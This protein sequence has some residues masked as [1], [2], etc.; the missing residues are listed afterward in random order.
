MVDAP[1]DDG[2]EGEAVAVDAHVLV[3]DVEDVTHV[4]RDCR[5]VSL[6]FLF[7]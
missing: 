4:W 3:L 5:E 1:V 6:L 7:E 2:L